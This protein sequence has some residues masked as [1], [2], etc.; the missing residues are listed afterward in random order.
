MPNN[1]TWSPGGGRRPWLA[2]LLLLPLLQGCGAAVVTGIAVGAAVLHDRRD[3]AT[4][5]ADQKIEIQALQIA[6]DDRDLYHD[7]RI[8]ATSYNFVVLL[9]GQCGQLESAERLAAG[10]SR[11]PKVKRV[12]DEVAIGPLAGMLQESQDTLITSRAAFAVTQVDLEGFD[13]TRV[14]IVTEAGI[15]Y[16][17]GLVTRAEA[18]AVVEQVRYVPDVKKV[19]KVFEYVRPEPAA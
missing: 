4:V 13:A 1:G 16:L 9:T 6:F 3:S 14:K 19:I 12:V 5:L 17:M 18:E 15:V 10:V 8:D 7:C 11:L 2:A